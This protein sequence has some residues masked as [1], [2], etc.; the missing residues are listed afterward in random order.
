MSKKTLVLGASTNPSRYANIA[1]NRL[2]SYDHEVVALGLR[3]GTIADVEIDTYP[4]SY[5]DID[6]VTMY[7]GAARQ[8]P[9]YNY[10]L[11]LKPKRVIFNPGAES[12]ELQKLLEKHNIEVLE[13]CTLVMLCALG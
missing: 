12:E 3:S 9:Y 4:E 10:I 2:R 13:A 5:S 6:T 11:S 8:V 1:D 7:L